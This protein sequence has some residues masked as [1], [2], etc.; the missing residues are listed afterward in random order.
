MQDIIQ[1][2][3]FVT[4]EAAAGVGDDSDME[5]PGLIVVA[6]VVGELAFSGRGDRFASGLLDDAGMI[7]G[8]WFR[9]CHGG[10]SYELVWIES[11]I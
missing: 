9:V 3:P 10:T 1:S 7:C 5:R 4:E 11:F 6:D 8:G 2:Y